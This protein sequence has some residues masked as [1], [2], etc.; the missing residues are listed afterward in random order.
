MMHTETIV[1]KGIYEELHKIL[2]DVIITINC[3][4]SN[5]LQSRLF[6]IFSNEIE[7][8]YATLLLLLHT[9]ITQLNAATYFRS[10]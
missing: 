3:I 1:A 2:Q 9:E 7:S 8:T 4:E 6:S 5:R 10:N